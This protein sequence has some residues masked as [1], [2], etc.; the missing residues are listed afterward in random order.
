VED[1]LRPYFIIIPTKEELLAEFFNGKR[2]YTLRITLLN[3]LPT[4][5]PNRAKITMTITATNVIIKPYSAKPCPFSL[6]ANNMATSFLAPIRNTGL[7][8][9]CIR[10][11]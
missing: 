3:M 4:A 9:L 1:Y 5:G 10:L 7:N 11:E 2:S 6:G 8:T